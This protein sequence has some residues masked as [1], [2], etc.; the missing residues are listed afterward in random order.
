MGYYSEHYNQTVKDVLGEIDKAL[1]AVDPE[2]VERF[3]DAVLKADQV[4]FVGVGRVLLSLQAICKRLAHLGIKTHYVGEITEPAI[5]EKDLLVVG[6]GSGGSGGGSSSSGSSS[7]RS[8][9]RW[10]GYSDSSVSH[11]ANDFT[12]G[13]WGQMS[14]DERLDVNDAIEAFKDEY[15]TEGMSDFE[16]ELLIIQWLVE[17]CTYEAAEGW[18]NATAYSCIVSGEAQ[19]AGYADAFLQTAKACGLEARYIHNSDHA[20]NLVKLDGD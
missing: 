8:D 16:K 18:S 10:E 7:G 1:G 19:C 2:S 17:N 4:Y 6:S 11:S 12:T 14:S 9:S 3:V 20:W 13:N 5:T 15:I